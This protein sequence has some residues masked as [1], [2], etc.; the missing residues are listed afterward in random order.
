LVQRTR[1]R[2]R[3]PEVADGAG[4]WMGQ[5][6]SLKRIERGLKG[7]LVIHS[8]DRSWELGPMGRMYR[9]IYEGLFDDTALHDW[10][11]FMQDIRKHSGSHKH[12]GGLIIYVLEGA[13][14]TVVDGVRHD[15]K[16]GD[17]LLLPIKPG[18]VE[19]QHFNKEPDRPARWV[20]F[21]YLPFWDGLAS[22]SELKEDSPLYRAAG[23]PSAVGVA[24]PTGS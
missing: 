3:E 8:D 14:H 6:R 1:T 23:K 13:G 11:V 10:W 21:I 7:K 24:P 9:F 15:W 20:A 19:H 4:Y 17:L 16:A 18:G 12:P 5:R 22:K 2:E